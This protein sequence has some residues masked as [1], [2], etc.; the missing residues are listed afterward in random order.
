MTIW[1][2]LLAALS[3]TIAGC[4]RNPPQ[5]EPDVRAILED[6]PWQLVGK[7]FETR[8]DFE[9]A[10]HEYH[11][12]LGFS[13]AWQPAQIVISAPRIRVLYWRP[14]GDASFELTADNGESFTAG[15]L[16]FKIHNETVEHL[17]E[18]DHQFF[19]GLAGPSNDSS[20]MPPAYRLSL[21]S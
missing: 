18:D 10:V 19:E 6:V 5:P 16:L 3:L 20:Q 7:P 15:E 11:R 4:S 1:K 9:R 2:T 8:A 12:Q 21:G 13:G 14:D 17:R